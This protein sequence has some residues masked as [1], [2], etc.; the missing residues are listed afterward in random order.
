MVALATVGTF[1]AANAGTIATVATLAGTAITTAGAVIGGK[2]EAEALEASG[3]AEQLALESE[4]EQQRA[5]AQLEMLEF[6]RTKELTQSRF[7]ALAA[8]SGLSATDA[9]ALALM[10]EIS[11]F[12]ALKEQRIQ[13]LGFTEAE[14]LEFQSRAV[15]RSTIAGAS[16]IRTGSLFSAAGRGLAG[17][18]R[19]AT[20]FARL[21]S[22]T[23][24]GR[25]KK[26]GAVPLPTR[27]TSPRPSR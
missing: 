18:S 27:S 17:V 23:P 13:E 5:R 8:G 7:Q 24:T 3:K 6:R 9:G 1:L 25:Y 15:G 20:N 2:A 12:G 26:S 10:E 11:E 19:A 16:A 22:P 4:V 21:Q 14:K